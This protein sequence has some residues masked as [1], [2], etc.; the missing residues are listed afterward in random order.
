MPKDKDQYN[1]TD[2]ESR[3][4]P[5]SSNKK[6]FIQGFN[7]LLVVDEE[8]QIIVATGV[9]PTSA[10]CPQ[11]PDMV[12]RMEEACG[13]RPKKLSGDTGFFSE[14]NVD[15][16]RQRGID[17][18]IPPE[19]Q[20]HAYPAPKAPRGRI[21]KGLSTAD[22]MRRKLRTKAGRK[23]YSRRK[24]IV[25]PS[26]GQIKEARGFRR[27]SMR[28]QEKARGEWALVGTTHNILKGYAT[29]GRVE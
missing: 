22:R 8:N 24:A 25:E 11:L 9:V 17:A 6:A 27:F 28:G 5:D 15:Y 29:V 13:K 21:P 26:I 2:P 12:D 4:M 14:R 10:D 19:K 20:K 3:I 18:Y 1:F 23:V 7:G 16:L